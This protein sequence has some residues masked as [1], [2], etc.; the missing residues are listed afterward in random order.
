M[1]V[2]KKKQE[3]LEDIARQP[4]NVVFARIS[5]CDTIQLSELLKEQFVPFLRGPANSSSG[6]NA[7]DSL[8]EVC[9][10]LAHQRALLQGAAAATNPATGILAFN[11]NDGTAATRTD[12]TAA[13][14]TTSDL[15]FPK[16]VDVTYSS[17]TSFP[18]VVLH[19]L[20]LSLLLQTQILRLQMM[21]ESRSSISQIFQ[22]TF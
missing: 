16:L 3:V 4:A 6:T 21:R 15:S 14:N 12:G 10:N 1:D 13:H 20:K 5:I 18:F 11:I 19:D 7:T 22:N 17:K 2:D 8:H 9:V